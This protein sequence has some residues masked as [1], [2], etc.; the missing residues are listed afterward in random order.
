MQRLAS[1]GADL[2]DREIERV[3]ERAKVA[4]A[5]FLQQD[6]GRALK[7]IGLRAVA[8]AVAALLVVGVGSARHEALENT[9]VLERLAA[10]LAQAGTIPPKT[11][12]GVAQL[13][14]RP[15]YDC[16]QL[17]CEPWLEKRNTDARA[18][19]RAILAKHSPPATVA[20]S[21]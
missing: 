3:I 14:R 6:H 5:Q 20:A 1:A 2:S 7:A 17:S 10:T 16:G 11:L 8:Y 15:D 18:G 19:L 12:R 21:K 9:R 4:R 13:L